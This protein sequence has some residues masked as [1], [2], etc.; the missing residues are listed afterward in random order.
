MNISKIALNCAVS[1]TPDYDF[2]SIA[3]SAFAHRFSHLKSG[4]PNNDD[5]QQVFLLQDVIDISPLIEN[6][7][8][9]RLDEISQIEQHLVATLALLSKQLENEF[10]D[11]T[12]HVPIFK[13]LFKQI[14]DDDLHDIQPLKE[15]MS[16]LYQNA[17]DAERPDIQSTL[18]DTMLYLSWYEQGRESNTLYNCGNP[19]LLCKG[20][21]Q[22]KYAAFQKQCND[23][24]GLSASPS[25]MK[26]LFHEA[27]GAKSGSQEDLPYLIKQERPLRFSERFT[28]SFNF[29]LN[30]C[31]KSIP[32]ELYSQLNAVLKVISS[33]HGFTLRDLWTGPFY[34][35]WMSI[36]RRVAEY[37]LSLFLQRNYRA[38]KSLRTIKHGLFCVMIQSQS[39]NAS[40]PTSRP[41][42]DDLTVETAIA[43]TQLTYNWDSQ[44]TKLVKEHFEPLMDGMELSLHLARYAHYMCEHEEID[45]IDEIDSVQNRLSS[46]AEEVWGFICA[47]EAEF[48]IGDMLKQG[49]ITGFCDHAAACYLVK[50]SD[51]DDANG[52]RRLVIKF[53]NAVA[54]TV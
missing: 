48:A 49:E 31:R 38:L 27:C 40:A 53:E 39:K 15:R 17:I 30:E 34:T 16:G 13:N 43:L 4:C 24:I 9:S 50:E 29:H 41:Y 52:Y 5:I 23:V 54:A 6:V 44:F 12:A 22:E 14:F 51:H 42:G 10:P 1:R 3:K 18:I 26:D 21:L 45:E 19:L 35:P 7:K 32:S 36:N 33:P 25:K 37:E 2:L 11:S 47:P 28:G 20:F 8:D 46:Q